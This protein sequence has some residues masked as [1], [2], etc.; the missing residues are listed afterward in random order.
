[1]CHKEDEICSASWKWGS[2]YYGKP[3]TG[4]TK[5]GVGG[6]GVGRGFKPSLSVVCLGVECGLPG[7]V[8]YYSG[9]GND[10]FVVGLGQIME[11]TEW[12][13]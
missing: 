12:A 1:M 2:I 4:I 10:A 9:F 13:A 6:N 8:D 5:G 11:G 7:M 3:K